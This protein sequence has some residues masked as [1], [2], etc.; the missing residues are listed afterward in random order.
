MLLESVFALELN[1]GDDLVSQLR[2]MLPALVTA[3][4]GSLSVV[5]RRVGL[6]VRTL[7]RHLDADGTTY[8][9]LLEEARMSQVIECFNGVVWRVITSSDG[10]RR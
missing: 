1:S 5:A 7:R 6:P 4:N 9:K 10:S 8:M 2:R 3:R